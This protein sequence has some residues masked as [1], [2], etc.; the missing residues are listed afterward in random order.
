MKVL[1]AGATG[2][3]GK[4]ILE[5]LLEED[6]DVASIVRDRAKI[7]EVE[8]MGAKAVFTDLEFDVEFA[9]EGMEAVIFAAGAAPG[10]DAAKSYDVDRNGAIKL[11]EAC[12]RNAVERFVMLS[13]KEI[14]G[15]DGDAG[16]K[17][18]FQAK[19]EAEGRL[20]KSRLN[21]TIIRA[22]RLNDEAESGTVTAAPDLGKSFGEISRA[23][24]ARVIVNA[25]DN[26]STYRKVIEVIGGDQPI[27]KA[28]NT[29]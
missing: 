29:I 17:D 11:I 28:L 26:P 14:N 20:Q 9:V 5:L 3:T 21:Y 7:G 4:Q 8:R 13:A 6:H 15:D 23:D 16:M 12:E 1:V 10:K 19:K 22:G 18:Y 27:E 25:L 2:K 24:V